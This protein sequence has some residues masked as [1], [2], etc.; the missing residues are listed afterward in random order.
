[1]NFIKP[2][3]GLQKLN[4][5]KPEPLMRK[6]DRS[7]SNRELVHESFTKELQKPSL[8]IR[9]ISR[10]SRRKIESLERRGSENT[11][12]NR[13]MPKQSVQY[14]PIRPPMSGRPP[15]M[16]EQHNESYDKNIL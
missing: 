12:T 7:F 16:K 5:L 10:D 14:K 1:M 15:R 2:P 13:V 11:P 8:D 3:L 9:A 4:Q 6:R